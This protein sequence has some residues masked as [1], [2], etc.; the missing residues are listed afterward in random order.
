MSL[1]TF[2]PILIASIPWNEIVPLAE[3]VVTGKAT[4]D[5]LLTA[6]PHILDDAVDFNAILPGVVGTFLEAEDGVIEAKIVGWVADHA[7]AKAKGRQPATAVA[8]KPGAGF[9]AKLFGRPQSAT[10]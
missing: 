9:F 8:T 6:I 4:R 1:L 5:E 10:T 3:D 2:I 7:I